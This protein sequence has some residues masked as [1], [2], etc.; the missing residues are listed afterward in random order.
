MKLGAFERKVLKHYS[1]FAAPLKARY[2]HITIAIVGPIES[3][4][5]LYLGYRL[6]LLLWAPLKA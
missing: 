2:F 1:Y 6:H 5:S 4:V 3:V